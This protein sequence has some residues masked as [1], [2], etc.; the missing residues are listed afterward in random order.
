[1]PYDAFL[2]IPN[3]ELR[4]VGAGGTVIDSMQTRGT[5][6]SFKMPLGRFH[7]FGL[8]MTRGANTLKLHDVSF[9]SA[10]I[11]PGRKMSDFNT[12]VEERN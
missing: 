10:E 7:I 1:M 12:E 4:P 9:K 6:P 5:C 8:L 3:S 11:P 2:T